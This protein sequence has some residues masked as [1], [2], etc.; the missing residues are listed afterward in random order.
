MGKQFLQEL[1]AREIDYKRLLRSPT[2]SVVGAK[3]DTKLHVLGELSVPLTFNGKDAKGVDRTVGTTVTFVVTDSYD[4]PVLLSWRTICQW[5]A[6]IMARVEGTFVEFERW[7]GVHMSD[8][9]ASGATWAEVIRVVAFTPVEEKSPSFVQQPALSRDWHDKIFSAAFFSAGR[10]V[11]DTLLNLWRNEGYGHASSHGLAPHASVRSCYLPS[12]LGS[13]HQGTLMC[14][15][16]G[17]SFSSGRG[18]E[19]E[20]HLYDSHGHRAVV[21]LPSRRLLISG[22]PCWIWRQATSSGLNASIQ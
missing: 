3:S 14:R 4:G 12:C 18:L 10:S 20:G 17:W 6:N 2:I 5:K 11:E 7:P 19:K 22:V 1:E 13:Q 15:R 21:A 16:V 9:G 8:C